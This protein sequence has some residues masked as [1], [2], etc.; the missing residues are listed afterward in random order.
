MRSRPRRN[1][2]STA[3]RAVAAEATLAPERLL[4]PLFVHEG[5]SDVAIDSM[6][7]CRRHSLDGLLREVE[8]ALEDG[9]TG[10]VL[11]PA[12]PQAK[13]SPRGAEATTGAGAVSCHTRQ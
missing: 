9:L 7:G 10:I 6:P 4:L 11:F 1:R 8:G 12:V 3:L 2:R 13:K 5:A